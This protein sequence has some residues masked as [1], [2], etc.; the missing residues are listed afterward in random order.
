MLSEQE[1]EKIVDEHTTDDY[2]YDIWCNGKGVARAIIADYQAKLL[3][4]VEVPEVVGY[5]QLNA[6]GCD[7][8]VWDS[9][10]MDDRCAL[11]YEREA[12]EY[13]AAAA[14]QAREKALN[15]AKRVCIDLAIEY[16]DEEISV[17]WVKDAI[18]K[19]KVKL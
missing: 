17:V 8:L 7:E 9:T 2:G 10:Q 14:A 11:V 12:M 4:G 1:I 18:E 5:V 19:L 15:E 16:E 13:A 6:D 3:A